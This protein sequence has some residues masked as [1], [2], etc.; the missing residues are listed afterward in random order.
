MQN[1]QHLVLSL[2]NGKENMSLLNNITKDNLDTRIQLLSRR[3]TNLI[4][5]VEELLAEEQKADQETMFYWCLTKPS[6]KPTKK[7]V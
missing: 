4:T 1:H 3:I 6:Y 7:D 2:T 5:E